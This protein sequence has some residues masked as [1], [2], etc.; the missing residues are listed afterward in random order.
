MGSVKVMVFCPSN[1]GHFYVYVFLK[2]L[3]RHTTVIGSTCPSWKSLVDSDSRFS[4][5]RLFSLRF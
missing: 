5:D 3:F 2:V 1:V 4:Q